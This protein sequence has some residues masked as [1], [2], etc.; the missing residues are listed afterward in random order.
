MK[1][2]IASILL[3]AV[4]ALSLCTSALAAPAKTARHWQVYVENGS[5]YCK[6]TKT[7]NT[8]DPIQQAV[9]Q[10]TWLPEGWTLDM[11]SLWNGAF[12]A[13]NWS[14]SNGEETLYFRCCASSGY[15][16][17]CW[18]D[19]EAD[20]NTPKKKTKIQGYQAEL[21]Q[22]N[23]KSALAWEDRQGDLFLMLHT[24]SLTQADLEKI[25][26]SA[27][28]VTEAMPEYRLGW[29]PDQE[30]GLSRSTTMPGYVRD[31]GGTPDFIRFYYAAQPLTAPEGMPETVT[32]HGVQAQ[33]WLGN[34]EAEGT[35][36][37]SSVS[38]KTVELP[39]NNTWSTILWTDPETKI[40]FC[41]QGNKLARETMVRMA[42]SVALIEAVPVSAQSAAESETPSTN[43]ATPSSN[44]PNA[45]RQSWVA[46]GWKAVIT[47]ADGTVEK[48]PNFSELFPGQELPAG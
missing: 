13:A 34:T 45:S 6:S 3:A 36:V 30:Q 26:N 5:I 46:D 28:E 29:T 41:I 17:C 21:W 44:D 35:V 11:G 32:V 39:N 4:M 23:K 14:Y 48:V 20:E 37:T 24:G 33:L 7:A 15:S 19:F 22:V 12:P 27:V 1:K 40:C 38:G 25:A 9:W 2:R 31:A 16:F 43:A 18:L 47:R 10:P 42:E 8:Q